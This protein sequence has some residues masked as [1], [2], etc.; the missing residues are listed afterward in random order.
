MELVLFTVTSVAAVPPKLTVAFGTKLIP[1]MVTMVP[2]RLG[3]EL[4]RMV[5]AIGGGIPPVAEAKFEYPELPALLYAR[6]R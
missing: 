2:P 5:V 1:V 3:P 4:G 6:T